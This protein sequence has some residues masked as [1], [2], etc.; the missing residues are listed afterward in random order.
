[1]RQCNKKNVV[2]CSTS[3]THDHD[4]NA[5]L[6]LRLLCMHVLFYVLLLLT[7]YYHAF[8]AQPFC[9]QN[10]SYCRAFVK[11]HRKFSDLFLSVIVCTLLYFSFD[12]W[13]IAPCIRNNRTSVRV[14]RS[15][16]ACI[17]DSVYQAMDKTHVTK[18]AYVCLALVCTR[19]NR[20]LFWL[21][22]VCYFVVFHK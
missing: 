22:S 1:M 14:P 10:P 13:Q 20:L 16:I 9:V 4:V 18:R 11:K 12:F 2:H 3:S 15:T 8:P 7:A 5:S 6:Y 17:S 19:R 21:F